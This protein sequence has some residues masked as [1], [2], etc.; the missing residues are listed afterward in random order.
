MTRPS[1]IAHLA[2]AL[3][4]AFVLSVSSAVVADAPVGHSGIYGAHSLTDSAEY[5][6]A[7]CYYNDDSNMYRVRVRPPTVFARDRTTARDSQWVGWLVELRYRPDGGSWSTV[8]KSNVVKVKAWD[9]TPAAFSRST[10]TVAHTHGSGE[11]R[12]IVR[13]TWYRPGTS[14]EWEGTARHAV[15]HYTYP[16]APPAQPTECPAGIL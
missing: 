13:M 9:D 12:V 16:L 15:E 4:A 3:G 6:G 7:R 14:D 10:V 8:Q 2:S 5:E 11:W 1:R